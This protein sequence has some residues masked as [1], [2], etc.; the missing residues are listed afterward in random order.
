MSGVSECM[1]SQNCEEGKDVGDKKEV[2]L[3]FSEQSAPVRIGHGNV[4]KQQT[5]GPIFKVRDSKLLDLNRNLTLNVT[6]TVIQ[7]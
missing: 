2:V 5:T 3:K 6:L 4:Y 7:T 1:K